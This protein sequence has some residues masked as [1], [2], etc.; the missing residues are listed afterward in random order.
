MES[1]SRRRAD[2]GATFAIGRFVPEA[3]VSR[4]TKSIAPFCVEWAL[5]AREIETHPQR[6]G[7]FTRIGRVKSRN[8][9]IYAAVSGNVQEDMV[10]Y[11]WVAAAVV[12]LMGVLAHYVLT[13]DR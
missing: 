12:G 10:T 7:S 2:I 1:A 5:R 11:W 3:V 6:V 13:G 4:C 8:C 9:S